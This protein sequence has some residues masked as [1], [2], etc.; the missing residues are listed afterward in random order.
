MVEITVREMFDAGAHFG[1]QTKRWNPKMRPY[2]YGAR[3]GVHIIDLQQ[4]QD[5]AE[6]ALKEVEACAARG[7]K[8]L[9]VGTK[10]QA[11]EVVREEAK[12]CNMPYV[13]KRWLGGMLTNY[14]TI[15][16]SLDRLIDLKTRREK[17]DFSGYTKKELLGV[18]RE[19]EKLEAVLG[20]IVEMTN[21]PSTLFVVDPSIEK[22]AVHEASLLGI[23]VI[24]ITDSNC[25][26]DPIDFPIPANDDALRCIQMFSAKV[27]DAC[28]EGEKKYQARLVEQA[29]FEKKEA[30]KKSD[31]APK[32]E[33]KPSRSTQ[34]VESSG[35]AYVA[36]QNQEASEDSNEEKT[37][38]YSAKVEAQEDST[39]SSNEKKVEETKEENKE[40]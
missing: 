1:H 12:R 33:K 2:I 10:K 20:G 3:S 40:S 4:T 26:P 24:A 8:I 21:L 17:N 14:D 19:I 27:A 34:D 16:Q 36:K 7:E 11:Q 9:F 15:R 25:D 39:A 23:K 28:I 32:D 37:D 30:K 5:M 22:I 35:T 38:S 13:T 29:E 18:D 6:A 31:E